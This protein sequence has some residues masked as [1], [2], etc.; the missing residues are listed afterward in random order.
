MVK[1]PPPR[2]A[3]GKPQFL[4]PVTARCPRYTTN[5]YTVDVLGKMSKPELF[6]CLQQ[7]DH[8]NFFLFTYTR[9]HCRVSN[10]SPKR[11]HPQQPRK[12]LRNWQS[13][14]FCL[15]V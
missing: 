4:V 14:D 1:T 10:A 8:L 9:Q 3:V 7:E 15:S 2:M 11:Q 6:E 12:N 5:M 13:V